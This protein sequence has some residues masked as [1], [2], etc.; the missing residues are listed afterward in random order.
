MNTSLTVGTGGGRRICR[1]R[2]DDVG[3]LRHDGF[4]VRNLLGRVESGIGGGNHLDP[5]GF[6]LGLQAIDLGL[7]PVVATVV[8]D[9]GRRG[10]HGLDLGQFLIGE[11][12]FR[13]R[14]RGLAAR[15]GAQCLVGERCQCLV[16]ALGE[17]RPGDRPSEQCCT[18]QCR[19]LQMSHGFLPVVTLVL[20]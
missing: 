17:G 7:A 11:G 20:A 9:N 2:H 15:T 14:N 4:D 5:H 13:G 3:V 12:D 10:A 8:H 16:R 19:R 6:K 18:Q 1:D